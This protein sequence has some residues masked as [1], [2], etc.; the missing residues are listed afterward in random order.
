LNNIGQ[1]DL[2]PTKKI[3]FIDEE[4]YFFKWSEFETPILEYFKNNSP[5]ISEARKNE[6]TSFV[7]S[8]LNDFSISRLKEKMPWGVEVPGDQE[9]VMY[10]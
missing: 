1:C 8:G 6:V 4:N 9:H 7:K 10:V 2:H 5:I 3:Q